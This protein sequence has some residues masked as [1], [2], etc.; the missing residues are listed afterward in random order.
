ME[1]F[2]LRV[3]LEDL[4]AYDLRLT[5]SLKEKPNQLMPVVSQKII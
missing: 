3:D 2:F 1:Q 4:Q 5:D